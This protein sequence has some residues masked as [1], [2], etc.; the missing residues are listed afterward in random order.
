MSLKFIPIV[1]CFRISFLLLNNISSYGCITFYLLTVWHFRLFCKH[2]HRDLCKHVFFSLLLG[3]HP[4]SG[5][6][7]SCG[8]FMF[9]F[10][11]NYQ[12][13]PKGSGCV[14]G[15][16]FPPVGWCLVFQIFADFSSF[17]LP[18]VSKWISLRSEN[19]LWMIL[20]LWNLLRLVYGLAYGLSWRMFHAHL[21]RCCV[22][23]SG[24]SV[25]EMSGGPRWSPVFRSSVSL[26]SPPCP[27][28]CWGCWRLRFC[29]TVCVSL[30][31]VSVCF[32]HVLELSLGPCLTVY[33]SAQP[34]PIVRYRYLSLVMLFLSEVRRIW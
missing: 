7:V 23:S 25:V 9:N 27:P 21:R 32:V 16:I 4:E 29:R 3:I 6:A 12:T 8:A 33:L 13:L 17:L 22:A 30:Q 14:C 31:S 5:I 15:F 11:R 28:H 19:M 2:L 34:T 10:L 24:Q 18:P 20:V 26:L 1:A